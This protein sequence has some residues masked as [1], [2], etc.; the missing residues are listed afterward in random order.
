MSGRAPVA[1]GF[2]FL[3]RVWPQRAFGVACSPGRSASS[4]NIAKRNE[5]HKTKHKSTVRVRASSPSRARQADPRRADRADRDV[6]RGLPADARHVRAD[7]QAR[8]ARR[9]IVVPRHGCASGRAP[10][11]RGSA[12]A[13]RTAPYRRAASWVRERTR[14]MVARIRGRVTHGAVSSCRVMGAR[15]DARRG[16][17]DPRARASRTPFPSCRRIGSRDRTRAVLAR[18]RVARQ[19]RT[20][21]VNGDLRLPKANTTHDAAALSL[22]RVDGTCVWGPRSWRAWGGGNPV[23]RRLRRGTDPQRLLGRLGRRQPAHAP[24][25]RGVVSFDFGRFSPS[26]THD[27]SRLAHPRFAADVRSGGVAQKHPVSLF[28]PFLSS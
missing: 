14:A 2:F 9:R 7:P 6:R 15:A 8:H 19:E 20:R 16:R 28:L 17:A 13:S 4:A 21:F 26:E 5:T 12:G 18:V 1:R 22:G 24:A 25:R 11:S 10:W 3:N 23:V 27:V